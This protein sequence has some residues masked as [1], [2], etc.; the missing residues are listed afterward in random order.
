MED[1][2]V[3]RIAAIRKVYARQRN[4]TLHILAITYNEN[5]LL[6]YRPFIRTA[7]E[8]LSCNTVK[9]AVQMFHAQ[10]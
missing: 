5:D 4:Y 8:F 2:F 7:K 9:A 10:N 1:H 3:G 6:F